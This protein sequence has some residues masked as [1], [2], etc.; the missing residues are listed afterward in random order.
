MLEISVTK[1]GSYT[2][3]ELIGKVTQEEEAEKL[4]TTVDKVLEEGEKTVVLKM[5]RLTLISSDGLGELLR[6]WSIANKQH[7]HIMAVHVNEKIFDLLRITRLNEYIKVYPT[8]EVAT[9]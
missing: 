9:R 2:L 8:E 4:R 3:V 6:L 7:A 5:D 1:K